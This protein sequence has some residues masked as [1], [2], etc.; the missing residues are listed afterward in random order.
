MPGVTPASQELV[1]PPIHVSEPASDAGL[2]NFGWEAQRMDGALNGIIWLNIIGLT[3][4]K[5]DP[6]EFQKRVPSAPQMER[7]AQN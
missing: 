4:T 1:Q 6:R 3:Q 5:E 7:S 2:K